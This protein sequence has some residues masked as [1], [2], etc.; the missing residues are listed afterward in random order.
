MRLCWPEPRWL[1]LPRAGTAGF[2]Q[3]KGAER[4]LRLAGSQQMHALCATLHWVIVGIELWWLLLQDLVL[5]FRVPCG[6][7]RLRQCEPMQP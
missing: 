6:V 1:S 3:G 4:N 5:T 2:V 7:P